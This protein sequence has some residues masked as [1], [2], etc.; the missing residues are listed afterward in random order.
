MSRQFV[1]L[2]VFSL[3]FGMSEFSVFGKEKGDLL[4]SLYNQAKSEAYRIEVTRV[5]SASVPNTDR[6]NPSGFMEVNDSLVQARLPFF[7]KAYSSRYGED[8]GIN[9]EGTAENMKIERKKKQVD[10]RFDIRD[11]NERYQV[12][13]QLFPGGN[14]S[15][16]LN[17]NQREAISYYGT[18][19]FFNAKLKNQN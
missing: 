3:I 12:F 14:A 15:V 6:F 5:M 8:A 17:S 7:G 19:K 1:L 4:D 9:I 18:Y 2:F 13:I 10:I 11:K 16:R